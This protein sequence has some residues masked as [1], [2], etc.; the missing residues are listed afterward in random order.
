MSNN[1]KPLSQQI[2]EKLSQQLKDGN[3]IFQKSE[4]QP[5]IMP[6]NANTGKNYSG[7]PALILLMKQEADPRWL[8]LE[9]G[10]FSKNNVM[11]GEQ[12]TLISFY[13]TR[14]MQPVVEDGKPVL[15]DNGK[16]KMASV[17]LDEPVL[18]T[19]F[20]FNAKQLKDMP[21]LAPI[22]AE[23]QAIPSEERIKT[24]IENSDQGPDAS[25]K[26]IVEKLI[27][28]KPNESSVMDALKANIAGL[29]LSAQLQTPF[30]LGDHVGYTQSWQQML[31]E[32]PAE[33]FKITNDAQWVADKVIGLEKKRANEQQ[34]STT[35]NKG[36]VIAYKGDT[37]KV[38]DILRGKTAQVE[39]GDGAKFKVGPKDG[40]YAAL[41]AAKN[42]PSATKPSSMI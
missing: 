40:L 39:N 8:T 3:S 20:L 37:I 7:V 22:L 42:N 30:E 12:G 24:I 16:P 13:K 34:A 27:A 36:D 19:A 5:L 31:K 21:E 33:L 10:N 2:A 9:Q 14:D 38:L 41:V 28:E 4:A 11:K 18:T 35:L 15:K 6:F 25:L 29:F 17:K 23:R 32:E 26:S 1:L